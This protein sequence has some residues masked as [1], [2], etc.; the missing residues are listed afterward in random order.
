MPLDLFNCIPILLSA[1]DYLGEL[2]AI[3]GEFRDPCDGSLCPQVP[4]LPLEIRDAKRDM[5]NG[6]AAMHQ[7]EMIEYITLAWRESTESEPVSGA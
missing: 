1:D 5:M 4:W 3:H 7:I 2:A 6:G